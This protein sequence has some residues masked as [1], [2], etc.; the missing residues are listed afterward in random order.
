MIHQFDDIT[1]TGLIIANLLD[2]MELGQCV[3]VDHTPLWLSYG[4]SRNSNDV[5]PST[6]DLMTLL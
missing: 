4:H 3:C 6:S 2:A 5:S 1:R